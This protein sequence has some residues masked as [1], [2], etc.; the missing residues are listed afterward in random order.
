MRREDV[1]PGTV[2]RASIGNARRAIVSV[3]KGRALLQNP[4]KPWIVDTVDVAWLCRAWEV[5]R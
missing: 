5:E 4:D 3:E 1:R 2:I